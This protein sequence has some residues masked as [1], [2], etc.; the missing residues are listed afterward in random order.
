M[1]L[2]ERRSSVVNSMWTFSWEWGVVRVALELVPT[3]ALMLGSNTS[4][5]TV[6][7]PK[8]NTP[9]AIVFLPG[10]WFT[11][12]GPSGNARCVLI[13]VVYSLSFEAV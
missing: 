6:E 2:V 5:G 11:K 9:R 7:H 1:G 10:K 8:D 4:Q 13:T 12:R 3:S